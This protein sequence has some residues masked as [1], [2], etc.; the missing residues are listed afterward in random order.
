MPSVLR[1]NPSAGISTQTW[2][3][4]GT[5]VDNEDSL[6]ASGDNWDKLSP[7]KTFTG[8]GLAG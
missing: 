7:V 5:C 3:C 2:E 8:E 6:R 4:I 1:R